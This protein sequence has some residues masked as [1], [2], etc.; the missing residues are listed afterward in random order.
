MVSASNR[1]AAMIDGLLDMSRLARKELRRRRTDLSVLATE[2]LTRLSESEPARK[3]RWSVQAGLE[4]DCDPTLAGVVLDNLLANA[5]KYT[6]RAAQPEISVGA[7]PGEAG[8]TVFVV[9][10]NGVGFDMRYA[11]KLFGVFQRLHAESEFPGTGIGLS[12]ARR[13]VQRHGGRIWA[14]ARPCEG[15]SFYFTLGPGLSPN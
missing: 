3:L 15:A 4:A 6:G 5:W 12:T 14:E 11:D 10:D 9:R 1:M 8:E 7:C 13:A 2:I